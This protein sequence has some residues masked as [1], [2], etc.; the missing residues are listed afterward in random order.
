MQLRRKRLRRRFLRKARSEPRAYPKAICKRRT[1]KPLRKKIKQGRLSQWHGYGLALAFGAFGPRRE[2]RRL[3]SIS[4][5][6]HAAPSAAAPM[7]LVEEEKRAFFA[8][9]GPDTP[10]IRRTNKFRQ[11]LRHWREQGLR[12]APMFLIRRDHA[13][14]REA[15]VRYSP[16]RRSYIEGIA[17]GDEYHCNA[18]ALAFCEQDAILGQIR[19]ERLDWQPRIRARRLLV[20]RAIAERDEVLTG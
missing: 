15:K 17:R 16:R 2:R 13:Q 14:V 1:T 9:A 5:D 4:A 19:S 11:L 18:I 6:C 12:L 3:R 10:E 8:F 20:S 7:A